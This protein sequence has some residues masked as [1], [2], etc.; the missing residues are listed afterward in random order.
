MEGGAVVRALRVDVK[1]EILYEDANGFYFAI[2]RGLAEQLTALSLVIADCRAKLSGQHPHTFGMAAA[3]RIVK[4][5]FVAL[6]FGINAQ[7]Q[8]FHEQSRKLSV[9]TRGREVECGRARHASGPD[10][11]AV[12]L[13]K[14]ANQIG[15]AVEGGVKEAAGIRFGAAFAK[16]RPHGF[17]TPFSAGLKQLLLGIRYRFRWHLYKYIYAPRCFLLICRQ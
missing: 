5:R 16:Q 2:R 4:G 9:A 11:N 1:A 15:V 13:H 12:R 7:P 14:H 3:H 8:L 10:G 6:I 17:N